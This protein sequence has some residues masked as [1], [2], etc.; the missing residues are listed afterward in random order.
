MKIA[1]LGQ[2]LYVAEALILFY[3]FRL[4]SRNSYGQRNNARKAGYFSEK[5][6]T[7]ERSVRAQT[8]LSFHLCFSVANRFFMKLA[9][10][11][12]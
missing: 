6:L 7:S 1:I 10:V 4:C 8:H 9:D 12:V 11:A 2:L 3:F 5:V